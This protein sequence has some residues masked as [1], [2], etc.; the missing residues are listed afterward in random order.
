M[1]RRFRLWTM[2]TDLA[3]DTGV[4]ITAVDQ[5]D[6]T[7]AAMMMGLVAGLGSKPYY[8][9]LHAQEIKR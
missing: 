8:R 1:R 2:W 5:A 6:A 3:Q 4:T 9:G 7:R